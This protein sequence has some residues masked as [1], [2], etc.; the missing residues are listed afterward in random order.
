MEDLRQRLQRF[1]KEQ[2]VSYKAIAAGADISLGSLYQFNGGYRDMKE[3]P[4]AALD[5]Y[6]KDRNY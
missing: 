2:G 6:L 3:E 1:H 4:A 5:K